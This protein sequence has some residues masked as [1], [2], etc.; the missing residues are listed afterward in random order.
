MLILW[1]QYFHDIYQNNL[2]LEWNQPKANTFQINSLF[3]YE[4]NK[5]FLIDH[6]KIYTWL[7]WRTA[8]RRPGDTSFHILLLWM[9]RLLGLILEVFPWTLTPQ[10]I[11]VFTVFQE[12]QVVT[13]CKVDYILLFLF[14]MVGWVRKKC[15]Y[16]F[17]VT[18][19]FSLWIPMLM[20]LNPK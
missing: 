18:P 19:A 3:C 12:N 4:K 13:C 14:L 2:P 6:L 11:T 7:L 17:T 8:T 10:F 1:G 5:I 15:G 16:I 20:G 9:Q